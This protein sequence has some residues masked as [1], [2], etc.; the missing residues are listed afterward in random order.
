MPMSSSHFSNAAAALSDAKA[1]WVQI[2]F[3]EAFSLCLRPHKKRTESVAC[4]L[5]IVYLIL[6]PHDLN[7]S[8]CSEMTPNE[9]LY[10]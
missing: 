2:L 10:V 6:S 4:L 9:S 5:F 8:K 3:E 7:D 1:Q